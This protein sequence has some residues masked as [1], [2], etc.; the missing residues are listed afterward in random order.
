MFSHRWEEKEPAYAELK[1]SIYIIKNS[2]KG[3][4][5]LR[6]FCLVAKSCGFHWAWSDTCC[7]DKAN[8][9]ELSESIISMFLW[10]RNSALT[11]V[12]LWDVRT[13]S[14]DAMEKS[15]WFKRG[16]TLQELL[17]PPVIQ[18][19]KQDWT[20]FGKGGRDEE[21]ELFNH[22]TDPE[23]LKSLSRAS[24]IAAGRLQN[25]APGI[26][27]ARERLMWSSARG[28]HKKEDEAYSMVGIHQL[29]IYIQYGEKE[30]AF[31]RMQQKLLET[32][33]K[34]DLLDW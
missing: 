17:A 26:G 23:L 3:M 7:I 21:G 28:V 14:H 30:A 18:L 27:S 4:V 34:L 31:H 10:Y 9:T 2:S 19:Y 25:F 15:I 32:S 8:N 1:E 16:W 13:N 12:Y 11:I 20:P 33:K 6:Q 22:K 29:N 5:K 24:G